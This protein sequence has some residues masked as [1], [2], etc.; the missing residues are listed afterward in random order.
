M[1]GVRCYI[2]SMVI[3]GHL[4]N[5]GLCLYTNEILARNTKK[6]KETLI[7]LQMKTKNSGKNGKMKR[8]KM[9]C[10]NNFGKSI[11][12]RGSGIATW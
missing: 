5:M 2:W 8:K 9:Y 3:K 7:T 1:Y 6:Y 12:G 10:F 4:K 11:R